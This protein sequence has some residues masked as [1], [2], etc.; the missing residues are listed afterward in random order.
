VGVVFCKSDSCCVLICTL[1]CNLASPSRHVQRPLQRNGRRLRSRPHC[2]AHAEVAVHQPHQTRN[3]V[4][5]T[6]LLVDSEWLLV[7]KQMD[8]GE[9]DPFSMNMCDKPLFV[10]R[11]DLKDV[12]SRPQRCGQG[13]SLRSRARHAP[14][15]PS[16]TRTPGPTRA[17]TQF[18]SHGSIL[19]RT[20]RSDRWQ[21]PILRLV[22]NGDEPAPRLVAWHLSSCGSILTHAT[23]SQDPSETRTPS[24]PTKSRPVGPLFA[25]RMPLSP[26][27]RQIQRNPP[28]TLMKA[29][30]GTTPGRSPSAP[31]FEQTCAVCPPNAVA[32]SSRRS[33]PKSSDTL[34]ITS[35]S[36]LAREHACLKCVYLAR[37]S[38]RKSVKQQKKKQSVTGSSL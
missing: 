5:C 7:Q 6:T 10:P 36:T 26:T 8:S 4:S 25:P 30:R 12:Q 21:N 9:L 35:G 15:S 13:P 27:I 19:R 1:I 37:C 3:C 22:S 29:T 24:T 32:P 34:W 2:V 23:P 16:S 14:A 28:A 38:A 18:N 20:S 33:W 11:A 17:N 31:S